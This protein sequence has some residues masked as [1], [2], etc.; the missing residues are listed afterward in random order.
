V[1]GSS[2]PISIAEQLGLRESVVKRARK[3]AG[4]NPEV[5][6]NAIEKL[7]QQRNQMIDAEMKL[8]EREQEL[9]AVKER[10]VARGVEEAKKTQAEVFRKLEEANQMVRAAIRS[11]QE[12]AD[13]RKLQRIQKRLKTSDEQVKTALPSGQQGTKPSA[14]D[15]NTAVPLE[16]HD[17]K[18][19]QKVYLPEHGKIAIIT[20]TPDTPSRISVAIGP[21]KI[22]VPLSAL[23]DI[24][25]ERQEANITSNSTPKSSAASA[26]PPKTVDVE[27]DLRGS[28]V[29]D[30]LE[31]LTQRLDRATLEGRDALFVI[32]GHGS[33]V[34]KTALRKRLS[35]SPYVEKW[36]SANPEHGGDGTTVVYLR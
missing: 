33:G 20:Q 30:A 31:A 29:E 18:E 36:E 10:L 34:L 2:S 26:L 4:E 25:K 3:L 28:R 35:R 22:R 14:I 8:R 19:G 5:L 16:F 23:S 15:K 12:G 7:E 11:V 21:L 13:P 9:E 1:A 32:H 6:K 17:L 24:P 27:V